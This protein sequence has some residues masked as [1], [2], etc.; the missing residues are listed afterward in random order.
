LYEV[1]EGNEKSLKELIVSNPLLGK[2]EGVVAE[3]LTEEEIHQIREA[4]RKIEVKKQNME[5][6]MLE[7]GD[8]E[9]STKPKESIKSATAKREQKEKEKGKA[10][11]KQH[12]KRMKKLCAG[13]HKKKINPKFFTKPKEDIDNN[14]GCIIEVD[15]DKSQKESINPKIEAEFK[16]EEV[17]KKMKEKQEEEEE[18]L[19]T[20]RENEILELDIKNK[21]AFL[22]EGEYVYELFG[23]LV[24]SGSAYGGHYFAYIKNLSTN[25]WYSYND[26]NVRP[27]RISEIQKVF[28]N[29]KSNTLNY[30]IETMHNH[31]NA[32]MLMYR[33]IG[34][35][36]VSV[37]IGEIPDYVSEILDKEEK[38][39]A[40]HMQLMKE[41]ELKMSVKIFYGDKMK[42]IETTRASTYEQLLEEVMKVFGLTEK[43]ENCRLRS[44][45]V[46]NKIMMETYTGKDKLTLEEL[47]IYL[48]KSLA[49]EVKKDEDS[50]ED[51]DPEQIQIKVNVWREDIKSL[52]ELTLKP[53]RIF[54]KKFAKLKELIEV[55]EKTAGIPKEFIL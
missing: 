9:V 6:V 34:L 4:E 10:L 11:Y 30:H 8:A 21:E 38:E 44:Y 23:I 32:Y 39:E 45:N 47:R 2:I 1:A 42:A 33:K 50:F 53:I 36:A 52:D 49:L 25:N 20:I 27:M 29:T 18:K 15:T 54:I 14:K 48:L 28:G 37:D 7:E 24:H 22:K 26:V 3:A 35:P 46:P 19:I 51:Y 13:S 55:L 41:R 31:T 43:K 16:K 40:I 17:K 12:M 5:N